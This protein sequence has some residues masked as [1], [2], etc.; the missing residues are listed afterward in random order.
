[1][2]KYSDIEIHT[3][4]NLLKRGFKWI[5]RGIY[6]AIIA[7]KIKPDKEKYISGNVICSDLVPIFESIGCG[8]DPVSLEA[9]VHTQILDDV[10]RRYLSAVIR[11]F[12]DNVKYIEKWE[13]YFSSRDFDQI[14]IR[15]KNKWNGD[16]ENVIL[17]EFIKGTMYKGMEPYKKYTLEELGL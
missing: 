12:R 10:E 1:M 5:T 8:D 11:P 6:G 7:Y 17:P 13:Y 9:I 3:A 15:I 14:F 16:L 4:E 2:A